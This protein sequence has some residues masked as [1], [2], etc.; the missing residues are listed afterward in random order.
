MEVPGIGAFQA[1]GRVGAWT[2]R[3]VPLAFSPPRFPREAW[4]HARDTSL[5]GALPVCVIVGSFGAVVAMQGL[6]IFR[7]FGTQ[8]M[9]PSLV[10][11]A[12]LREAAPTFSG[13]MISA[14][15]GSTVAAELAVMRVKEEID[16]TEVMSVDALRFHVLPRVAGLLFASPL[17]TVLSGASGILSAWIVTVGFG[18]V[19]PGAFRENMFG[20]LRTSDIFASI[21]KSVSYGLLIGVIATY[22]G[23]HASR[24]AR[25]VGEAANRAVV[26]SIVCIVVVNYILT[27]AIFGAV[28]G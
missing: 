20:F 18:W 25:G 23:F 14:Q 3:L 28:A 4:R 2:A 21:I 15:A 6:N 5:R 24:G 8:A 22:Q 16:A 11:V 1:V 19:S 10:V 9:L 7:I 17:L 12:I 26:V 13:I 27:S